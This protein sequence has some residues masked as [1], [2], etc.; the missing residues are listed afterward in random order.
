MECLNSLLEKTQ[1]AYEE[2]GTASKSIKNFE[3]N[4]I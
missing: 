3:E 1:L 2:K 4:S